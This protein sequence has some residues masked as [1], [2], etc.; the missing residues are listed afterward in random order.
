V[1]DVA[2]RRRLALLLFISVAILL[3]ATA[4][5]ARRDG[6]ASGAPL[7]LTRT[8]TCLRHRGAV[9]GRVKPGNRRL[10][11]L[12]D[13]AQKTSVQVTL[14]RVVVGVAFTRS[15]SDATL[16]FE[17]LRVPNDPLRLEQ[18]RNVVLVSPKTASAA[19]SAV[20]NCLRI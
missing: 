8:V 1:S 18:R 12:R 20:L 15:T 6:R 11:A 5:A 3:P 9:V 17:L 14:R 7:S 4:T 16:L 2:T 19:R 13:L 10:R